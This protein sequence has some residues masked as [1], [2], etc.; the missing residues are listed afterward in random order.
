[1]QHLH[2]FKCTSLPHT[3]YTKT[4]STTLIY[5]PVRTP[6]IM[7]VVGVRVSI[8]EL[9]ATKLTTLGY[10]TNRN[11]SK[12]YTCMPGS[13]SVAETISSGRKRCLALMRFSH[14][15]SVNHREHP[16]IAVS[17]TL[18]QSP[19]PQQTVTVVVFL[20]VSRSDTL[21]VQGMPSQRSTQTALK[22]SKEDSRYRKRQQRQCI[23]RNTCSLESIF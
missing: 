18:P 2:I 16:G 6:I 23:R 3:H 11:T 12:C 13:T 5:F 1:M 10:E 7:E 21:L 4:H 8:I 15:F 20:S 19:C 17:P 14:T 9:S 22:R